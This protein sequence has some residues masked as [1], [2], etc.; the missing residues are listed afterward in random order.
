MTGIINGNRC[1]IAAYFRQKWTCR[2]VETRVVL[3]QRKT[4]DIHQLQIPKTSS[5]SLSFS[6]DSRLS[7]IS[8]SLP[9][10]SSSRIERPSHLPR[11]SSPS[12]AF[13]PRGTFSRFILSSSA[14]IPRHSGQIILK[15]VAQPSVP[16]SLLSLLLRPFVIYSRH[17]S[18]P[19]PPPH[20]SRPYC[21][22][23]ALARFHAGVASVAEGERA[24]DG[25]VTRPHPLFTSQRNNF[26]QAAALLVLLRFLY[27]RRDVPHREPLI[28]PG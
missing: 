9:R 10:L 14:A 20:L 28:R 3:I 22:G 21:R 2:V 19:P 6:L 11:G 5:S 18:T 17:R 1:L 25:P 12:E 4:L 7:N 26:M 15:S 8:V 24:A 23:F 27:V 13:P 16:F